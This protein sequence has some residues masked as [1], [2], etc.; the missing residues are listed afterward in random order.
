M[1]QSGGQ[2][3][4]QNAKKAKL[5]EGALK[6]ALARAA[7]SVDG[8]IDKV[9]DSLVAAG[10]AGEQWAVREVADRLDGKAPQGVT[11][12]GDEDSPLRISGVIRRIVDPGNTGQP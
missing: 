8:G 2:P 7:E 5:F 1:A 3:G 10:I 9:A 6:R 12:S 4:N 11:I